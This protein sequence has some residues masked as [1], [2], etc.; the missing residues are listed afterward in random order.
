MVPP[1]GARTHVAS[2]YP[3]LS[4]RPC[5]GWTFNRNVNLSHVARAACIHAAAGTRWNGSSPG[6]RGA[7]GG[8]PGPRKLPCFLPP[9]E[10][11]PLRRVGNPPCPPLSSRVYLP[12]RPHPSRFDGG[13]GRALRFFSAWVRRHDVIFPSGVVDGPQRRQ[14]E[15]K[16]AEQNARKVG[17]DGSVRYKPYPP[18]S[19]SLSLSVCE[20]CEVSVWSCGID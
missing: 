13:A 15:E 9:Q 2:L 10:C 17:W 4:F 5:V 16:E 12:P 20:V 1:Q 14:R 8:H 11:R 18:L 7:E 6:S 19:L 3:S